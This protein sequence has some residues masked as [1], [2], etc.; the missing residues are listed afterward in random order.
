MPLDPPSWAAALGAAFRH[1]LRVLLHS[2]L[3]LVFQLAFLIT[4]PVAVFLV[5][6]FVAADEA[7]LDLFLGFLPWIAL[8]FTPALAMK[9]F[10]G[11]GLDREREML[12]ALPIPPGA[13]VL[14]TWLAGAVVLLATLAFTAPFAATVAWLGDP[15]DGA[16]AA[17]YLGAACLLASFYAV[18]LFASAIARSEIGAFA[19]ALAILFGLLL[20][21]WD[22]G[23]RLLPGGVAGPLE[24]AAYASPKFWMER[25]ATGRVEAKALAY[26]GL[27]TALPL[28]CA[29][30]ALRPAG[31]RPRGARVA[32][33]GLAGLAGGVGLVAA[34]PSRL[35]VDLTEERL[36]SL[37]PGAVE[38]A[39]SLP[40]G[41][42]VDLFR[43]RGGVDLPSAVAAYGERVETLL[44]RLAER[45]GG[46]LTVA[47][48]QAAPDEES[49]HAALEAGVAAT[50]LSSGDS[51]FLGAS[52]S[53]GGRRIAIPYFDQRREGV[54]EYDLATALAGLARGR[55]LKVGVMTPLL[56]PGDAGASEPGLSVVGELRRAYDVAIV[57]A[58]ADRLPDGID[59]LVV[60]GATFLKREML[61]AIDQATMRG[62][63]L[64]AMIDPRLRLSPASDRA[65]PSPSPAVDDLSD[66][67]A[68]YGM[69]Y[70]GGAVAGDA[71]LAT[72]VADPAG[73]TLA[74]PFWMRLSGPTLV[75]PSHAVTRG[76][77]D[78]LFVEPGAFTTTPDA[79]LA[80]T[81]AVAGAS[82]PAA[83]AELTPAA[84]AAAFRPEG[85]VRTI[86]AEIGGP[87]AS[88]F[89][90]PPEGWTGAPHVAR[91]EA[92]AAVFG[93]ADVDW[94]LDPFAY[95]PQAEADAVRRPRN[96][97]V[98]LFLNMV[99]R[100]AG[101]GALIAA[102]SRGSAR[103]PLTEV[104]E[105]AREL[106][107][108][109]RA[110]KEAAMTRI[111]EVE[112]RI[113]A[114][115]E[116]A[117]AASLAELPAELRGRVDGLRA[118]LA[119]DRRL[120][121]RLQREEREA[122]ETF[123][124]RVALLNLAG[125]PALALA[126]AGLVALARRRS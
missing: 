3:T 99:E 57:P 22:G 69:R 94:I 93:V 4:L 66:L 75:S 111:G 12:L 80:R 90:G 123:R 54:L 102:R 37:S 38:V 23:G 115:P 47:V 52:L 116:A 49:G 78:L 27:L 62:V 120:L 112:R 109:Q 83:L 43:T 113:A 119:P 107:Q 126:F 21:G 50:P 56:A 28:V 95:E 81:T 118:A 97:N 101:G 89:A 33:L 14:G 77:D 11:R 67:L 25:M 53:A 103:R 87:L 51:F 41:G 82:P 48:R 2:R 74:F 91:S 64:V 8:V 7:S 60:I 86:A 98:A 36:F 100:A 124:A 34:L 15:D 122:L 85:G 76:L 58:F 84:A 125:G 30:A 79:A 44:G 19:I 106:A 104:A 46:R 71:A 88:A 70:E 114:L 31:G 9:A 20:I 29:A 63:G 42:R 121:R 45:S 17:G 73:K 5:A 39:R 35:A 105:R 108:D 1:Q 24:V 18:G 13:V 117:G 59:A 65:S 32:L 61:Y 16:M 72:P 26:F 96:G 92:P 68:A 6:D 40:E 55:P 110:A 10:S